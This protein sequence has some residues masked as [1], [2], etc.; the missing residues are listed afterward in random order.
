MKILL[1]SN[2]IIEYD[3]R[4]R[5]LLKISKELGDTYYIARS[6]SKDDKNEKFCLVNSKTRFNYIK[7]ILI[8]IITALRIG[9][10]DVIFIDNRKAIIPGYIV[11][12]IKN[13]KYVI[14]D[15]RELYIAN[16]VKKISSKVG[17]FIERI[18]IRNANVLIAANH[19]RADVM[20]EYYTLDMKPLVYENI[21]RLIFK[22]DCNMMQLEDKY[23]SYFSN[24]TFKI[25][26]TSGYDIKRTNDVLVKSMKRLGDNFELFL[27]GGGKQSDL[28]IIERIISDNT[29]SNIRI[30]EK[31]NE[32]ELKYL[33]GHMNLGIV[34]YSQNDTNNKLCASG[35]IYEFIFEGI[36][37]VTTENLPLIELVKKHNIG[38]ADNQ[39]YDGI[40]EI[41]N[42]YNRYKENVESFSLTIN[43]DQNNKKLI[44]DIKDI[45]SLKG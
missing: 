23:K 10:I 29:L 33:L 45:L 18:G 38:I 19:F 41:F 8:T 11:K 27:V 42:N 21:R 30:I 17:C 4:L 14:Q 43:V 6:T 39:Y 16:E 34:N 9:K 5:E 40:M 24:D 13:T 28:D 25:I 1:I 7:F 12:I 20:K 32:C 26:S 22:K 2:G 35:K 44:S 36:P 15:V 3:G 31:I 37:V